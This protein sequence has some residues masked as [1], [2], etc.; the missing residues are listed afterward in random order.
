MGS[1]LAGKNSSLNG[2]THLEC[3]LHV[4]AVMAVIWCDFMGVA[5]GHSAER[6][7]VHASGGTEAGDRGLLDLLD[8]A[9]GFWGC[10]LSSIWNGFAA[11]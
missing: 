7:M 1:T 3:S 6:T 4:L 5:S 10:C 11:I 2:M 8:I 9:L